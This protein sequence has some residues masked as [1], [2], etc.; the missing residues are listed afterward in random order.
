MEASIVKHHVPGIG[1]VVSK[2]LKANNGIKG[3]KSARF[4]LGVMRQSR[5][6][7]IS[8]VGL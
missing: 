8:G 4:M 2:I 1:R 3:E 6:L 7:T 5:S